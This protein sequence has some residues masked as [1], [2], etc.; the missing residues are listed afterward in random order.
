MSDLKDLSVCSEDASGK[1]IA[2]IMA[3]KATILHLHCSPIHDAINGQKT[4]RFNS[5]QP[6]FLDSRDVT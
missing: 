6:F 2:A 1:T 3:Q 5:K 4:L